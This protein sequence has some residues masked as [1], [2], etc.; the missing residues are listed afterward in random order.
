M[1]RDTKKIQVIAIIVLLVA[2]YF[3]GV[4]GFIS[5]SSLLMSALHHFFHANAVHLIVNC[6]VLYSIRKTLTI[7]KLVAAW[8]IGSLSYIFALRPTIGFSDIIYAL[9]GMSTPPLTSRWWRSPSTIIFLCATVA[10]LFVPSVSAT[11]HIA[12]LVIG[13]IAS[14]VVR[15]RN[16][17]NSDYEKAK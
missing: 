13:V 14:C 15:F 11:T 3:A 1:Q 5:G 16:K 7:N 4:P 8:F 6:F 17:L 9:I 2:L 10:Y 12:S